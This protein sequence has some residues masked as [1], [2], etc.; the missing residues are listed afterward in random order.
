MTEKTF[1]GRAGKKLEHALLDFNID[2]T[3]AI[4]ADFGCSTGGFTDCLLQYGASKV[5]AID[6]AYGELDWK[7]R[8]NPQVVVMER[9]NV[10]YVELPEKVDFIC[11]DTGWTKQ[12]LVIP[13][14]LE[15][16]KPDGTVI[17]LIKPHYEAD[18]RVLRGGKVPDAELENVLE[19]VKSVLTEQGVSYEKIIESPIEGK[20]GGNKEFLMLIRKA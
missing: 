19:K 11:I 9:T 18:K 15:F 13:K 17:S 2:V 20:K 5:Y 3:G 12:T 6:T 1:V 8:N 7:L 16:L 14:A 4:C 10:L